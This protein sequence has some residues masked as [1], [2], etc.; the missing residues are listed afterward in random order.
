MIAVKSLKDVESYFIEAILAHLKNLN[1]VYILHNVTQDL[2]GIANVLREQS[3]SIDGTVE[4]CFLVEVEEDYFDHMPET[5]VCHYESDILRCGVMWF[6]SGGTDRSFESLTPEH[7]DQFFHQ[8]EPRIRNGAASLHKHV[9][10][11]LWA[12]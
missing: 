10:N 7:L 3:A 11:E 8:V 4:Q 5:V 6:S 2:S 12:T 9:S 1:P